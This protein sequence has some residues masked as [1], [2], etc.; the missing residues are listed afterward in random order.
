MS[1]TPTKEVAA[2]A[3]DPN[4]A[5]GATDSPSKA[6]TPSQSR[7]RLAPVGAPSP[8]KPTVTPRGSGAN[9]AAAVAAAAQASAAAAP[10]A[11]P[12]PAPVQQVHVPVM[13]PVCVT[14]SRGGKSAPPSGASSPTKGS[15]KFVPGD[16]IV[17]SEIEDKVGM[18]FEYNIK[19][20][21]SLRSVA[22]FLEEAQSILR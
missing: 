14:A 10:A 9:A 6:P 15:T 17:D 2:A 3:V 12:A 21:G 16:D 8:G 22:P 13:E 19:V 4:A 18:M 5:P 7:A 1:S 11:A 20:P